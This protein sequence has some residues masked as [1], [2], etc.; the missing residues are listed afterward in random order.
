MTLCNLAGNSKLLCSH[1]WCSGCYT[2]EWSEHCIAFPQRWPLIQ[3]TDSL[4]G[5]S[6]DRLH[7]EHRLIFKLGTMQPRGIS[8]RFSVLNHPVLLH[9]TAS[10]LFF[11]PQFKWLSVEDFVYIV[12]LSVIHYALYLFTVMYYFCCFIFLGLAHH[13]WWR[14]KLEALCVVH[15]IPHHALYM[16]L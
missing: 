3:N 10:A 15:V 12:V 13:T 6:K 1:A 8:N 7:T 2:S 9:L 5:S 16:N 4:Y 11:T 14:A